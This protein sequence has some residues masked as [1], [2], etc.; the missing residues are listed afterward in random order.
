MA[1]VSLLTGVYRMGK[2][3]IQ[4]L[5][6]DLFNLSIST[7]MIC[8]LQAQTATILETSYNELGEYVQTQNVNI[9]ETSWRGP[10]SPECPRRNNV[11]NCLRGAM[12]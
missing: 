3:P 5:L 12:V 4:Q 2:R 8:K 9:D 7:G 10:A 11:Y 6:S 1:L